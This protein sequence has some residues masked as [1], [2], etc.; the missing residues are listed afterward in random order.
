MKSRCE[1]VFEQC[2]QSDRTRDNYLY[3]LRKYKEFVGV[4]NTEE[5]LEADRK[6]I[7]EKVEDFVMYLKKRLNPNSF[8]SYLAPVV[9]FYD[10]ND[11]V[12]NK[13]KIRK[14]YPAKIKTMGGNS[15]TREDIASML[16]RTRKNRTRCIILI[17][18]STGCRV[19][20]LCE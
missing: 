20:A 19:S 11:I 8:G 3:T 12:L 14:M 4:Q 5:L 7:Q 9:L 17:C 18:T 1:I 16:S 15:Y 10:V 13:V 2:I 6:A